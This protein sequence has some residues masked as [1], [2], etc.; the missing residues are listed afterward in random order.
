MQSINVL[1]IGDQ[2][3]KKIA[4]SLPFQMEYG[5]SFEE[6]LKKLQSKHFDVLVLDRHLPSKKIY[7]VDWISKIQKKFLNLAIVAVSKD[8]NLEELKRAYRVGLTDHVVILKAEKD[9]FISE[10]TVRLPEAVLKKEVKS[11]GFIPQDLSGFSKKSYKC[12]LNKFD[13]LYFTKAIYAFDGN[14]AALCKKMKISQSTV[15]KRIRDFGIKKAKY[16]RVRRAI[17]RT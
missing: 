5:N 17:Y 6:G 12:F 4:S 2:V 8:Q 11:F 13:R 16:V 9:L 7:W 15:Y 3:L 14:I 1:F 10:L